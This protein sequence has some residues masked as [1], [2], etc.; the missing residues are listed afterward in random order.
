MPRLLL[1]AL[2]LLFTAAPAQAAF[3][4]VGTLDQ[5]AGPDACID[6]SAAEPCRDG[7]A[8]TP[9]VNLAMSPG[10]ST[11]LVPGIFD[12]VAVLRR[13]AVTGGLTQPAGSAGC[14]GPTGTPGC[15]AAR[16]LDQA[17]DA[18]FSPD[19]RHVYVAGAHGIAAFDHVDDAT[20]GGLVPLPGATACYS[21]DGTAQPENEPSACTD[22]RALSEL[23]SITVSHDGDFV[24]AVTDPPGTASDGI[25]VFT[26]DTVS[27]ALTQAPGAGGCVTVTRAATGDSGT[28]S[29]CG[30]ELRAASNP[31]DLVATRDALYLATDEGVAVLRRGEQGVWN[32]PTTEAGCV[33]SQPQPACADGRALGEPHS[34]AL[35]GDQL[36]VANTGVPEVAV[37]TVT[38]LGLSQAPGAQGCFAKDGSPSDGDALSCG[39][40]HSLGG[41]MPGAGVSPD[42][43][44]VA[45]GGSSANGEVAL[46][47]RAADGSIRQGEAKRGCVSRD[48]A[49]GCQTAAGTGN[50]AVL[51]SPAG[52][53]FYAGGGTSI[54][55]L[56][57]EVAPDCDGIKEAMTD[58]ANPV[59]LAFDCTDANREEVVILPSGQPREGTITTAGTTATYTPS[60]ASGS[61]EFGVHPRDT[62]GNVGGSIGGKVTVIPRAPE[63]LAGK[64]PLPRPVTRTVKRDRRG[65]MHFALACPVSAPVACEG[66]L[67]LRTMKVRTSRRGKRRVIP[68]AS[69]PYDIEP[70]NTVRLAFRP[71]KAVRRVLKARRLTGLT[72]RL[73]A[74]ARG[75]LTAATATSRAQLKR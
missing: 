34:L 23:K 14:V 57:R 69:L 67:V 37:L 46:F 4:P 58:T 9:F 2:A 35:A 73:T 31:S 11:V 21:N 65:R 28:P 56:R 53:H 71:T 50:S 61:F 8:M 17:Y 74:P 68:V 6:E 24:Y 16:N 47:E 32:Q 41:T 54:G 27:G 60:G 40:A 12:S 1:A 10:G 39:A 30:G 44:T 51:W 33:T 66:R 70:G 38:A 72:V 20:I 29:G 15:R 48:G 26:R 62:S 7:R 45:I 75:R 22:G 59:S 36:F 13:D 43:V 19:G 25:V 42:R 3:G 18:A 49:D 52:E 55:A 63:P 64:A 5:V